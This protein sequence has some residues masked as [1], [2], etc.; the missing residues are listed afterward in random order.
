MYLLKNSK[1]VRSHTLDTIVNHWKIQ[2]PPKQWIGNEVW[3]QLQKSLV[4]HLGL[5][6]L[7][8][9]SYLNTVST[10]KNSLLFKENRQIE[11]CP[12]VQS[13]ACLLWIPCL[14]DKIHFAPF[15]ERESRPAMAPSKNIWLLQRFQL[16]CGTRVWDQCVG[17]EYGIHVWD[18]S[19][20]PIVGHKS[21]T[22][23]WALCLDLNVGS[24]CGT[25]AW[26]TNVV[27]QCGAWM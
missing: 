19:V 2:I 22:Q 14:G 24:V 1:K 9:V 17:P 7:K 21:W 8:S 15:Q 5:G 25:L 13:K 6:V 12:P 20:G 26:Y 27:P 23:M 11:L 10:L 16:R 18:T 3:D 4:V